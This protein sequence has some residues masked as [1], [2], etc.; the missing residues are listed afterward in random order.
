MD[1]D[2]GVSACWT[3]IMEYQCKGQIRLGKVKVLNKRKQGG[4]GSLSI[5]EPSKFV[6]VE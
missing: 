3:E 1:R 2:N 5:S 6:L 4:Q